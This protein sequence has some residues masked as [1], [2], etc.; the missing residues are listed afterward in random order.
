M[1][2]TLRRDV[3]PEDLDTP[4]R[5]KIHAQTLKIDT[6]RAL[7]TQTGPPGARL[8]SGEM[9][10]KGSDSSDA[11]RERGRKKGNERSLTNMTSNHMT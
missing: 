7:A 10:R 3:E 8:R 4:T 5:M 11:N 1:R 2:Q 6:T 9:S